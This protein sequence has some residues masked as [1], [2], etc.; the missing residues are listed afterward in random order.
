MSKGIIPNNIR[1]I[2]KKRCLK[3][4]RRQ[5][6]WCDWNFYAHKIGNVGLYLSS[7]IRAGRWRFG[8][9][10][11]SCDLATRDILRKT[12]S[13]II[14]EAMASVVCRGWTNKPGDI[15]LRH[16]SNHPGDEHQGDQ[17]AHESVTLAHVPCLNHDH[18]VY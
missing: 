2:D 11:I 14:C 1:R 9:Q 15:T 4:K 16:R 18:E 17:D 3:V 6:D 7:K 13:D 10:V 5:G 8:R 12:V